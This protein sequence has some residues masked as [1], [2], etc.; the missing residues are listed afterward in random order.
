MFVRIH[1][2]YY[3]KGSYHSFVIVQILKGKGKL[4]SVSRK[5]QNLFIIDLVYPKSVLVSKEDLER[6][7]HYFRYNPNDVR[8][9]LPFKIRMKITLLLKERNLKNVRKEQIITNLSENGIGVI[10]KS[11]LNSGRQNTANNEM[12]KLLLQS[13]GELE[14]KLD[15]IAQKLTKVSE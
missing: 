12:V 9:D 8:Q 5:I 14:N 2:N 13:V 15:M 1:A 3:E 7:L 11:I 6:G 10:S 4:A